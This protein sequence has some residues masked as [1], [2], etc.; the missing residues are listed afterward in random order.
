MPSQQ[1]SLFSPIQ[2]GDMKLEHR[3][4]LAP[5]TRSRSPGFVA[6]ALN[7]L[8]YS[9]RATKGG[10]LISE[11]TCIDPYSNGYANVPFI[12]TKE[13]A[14]GWALS[15]EAVHAKGGYIY[16]Q[17][18]HVGRLSQAS[19][20]PDNQPPVSSSATTVRENRP[21]ARALTIAEIQ[22][23]VKSYANAAILA[24]NDAHFDGIEIHA[25]HG[26]LVEQF[27][28][29]N[30]NL[31]TDVYGGSIENRARFLF[32][33]LDAVVAAVPASKVAIR[34]SPDCNMQGVKDDDPKALY[35]YVLERLNEYNLAY[36]QLTEPLWG[37]WVQG[38]PHDQSKL[39]QYRPIL[40]NPLTKIMLTGGY[41]RDSAESAVQTGRADLIGFGRDFITNP[42]LVS[43]LERNLPLAQDK[44]V[45]SGHYSG[46]KEKY[47]D[48]PTW[49]EE[50]A[51]KYY[52]TREA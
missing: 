7:A 28:N 5:L 46:G 52:L 14:E 6:N 43:R 9:Q 17:L 22:E 34:I 45:V 13:H 49:E 25:A 47:T 48:Y 38:P 35:T 33:V 50:Q 12:F 31:R 37:A 32:E 10:L 11:G 24:I 26:Y 15:T 4:S 30:S 44:D 51:A 3:V 36:I 1:L 40:K 19:F 41:T 39:V 20:Q 42:D 2:V 18:W 29:S 23:T 21:P 16:A 27:L 8:Y